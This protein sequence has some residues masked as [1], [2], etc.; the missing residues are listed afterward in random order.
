MALIVLF[1]LQWSHSDVQKWFLIGIIIA[2]HIRYR[3][4]TGADLATLAHK[5]PYIEASH[6]PY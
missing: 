3:L 2:I 5:S 1:V 4:G 6:Q